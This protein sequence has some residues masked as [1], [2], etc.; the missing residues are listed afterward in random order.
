MPIFIVGRF[1]KDTLKK[2][3]EDLTKK[4]EEKMTEVGNIS[5][6]VR[7][8]AD[9]IREIK[10]KF[11]IKKYEDE[12]SIKKRIERI[13]FKISTGDLPLNEEKEL[14]KKIKNL[15]KRIEE[16]AK[17]KK[18]EWKINEIENEIN[19]LKNSRK[20]LKKEII[21]DLKEITTL[22]KEIKIKSAR[23]VGEFDDFLLGEL[24]TLKKPEKKSKE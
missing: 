21:D 14:A 12:R 16:I 10:S 2:E 24:A 3:L 11:G 5:K 4:R 19:E 8:K 18:S 15:E 13:D 9:E 23:N 1:M 6:T 7:E 22:R 20:K 17:I